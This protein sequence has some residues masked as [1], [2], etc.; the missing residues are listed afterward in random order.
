MNKIAI[1]LSGVPKF[2]HRSKESIRKWFP[3]ADIFAHIWD[4]KTEY[5]DRGTSFHPTS[6]T[7]IWDIPRLLN[8]F[9]FTRYE[10]EDFKNKN[11]FWQN[12]T[13]KRI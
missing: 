5:I 1:I 13:Y 8:N 11:D 10:T 3:S 6:Y 12:N 7:D 2:T 9:K 4:T